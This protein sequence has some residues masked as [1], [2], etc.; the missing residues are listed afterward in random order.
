V[1]HQIYKL[2]N[3]KKGGRWEMGRKG[4]WERGRRG[5]GGKGRLNFPLTSVVVLNEPF[6]SKLLR[7]GEMKDPHGLS[8]FSLR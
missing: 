6:R 3:V 7:N 8:R 1:L 2:I 4:E 5:E